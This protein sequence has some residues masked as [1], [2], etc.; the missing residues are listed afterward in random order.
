MK[1]GLDLPASF[2]ERVRLTFEGGETWLAELPAT[3]DF[4]AQQWGLTLHPPYQLSY[5]YAA[6]VTMRGGMPAVLK[7]GVPRPELEREI[8]ALQLYDGWGMCRLLASDVERGAMLLEQLQPGDM[9]TSLQDDDEEIRIAAQTMRNLWRVLPATHPFKPVCRWADGLTRLRQTFDGDVGPFPRHLVE[10]AESMFAELFAAEGDHFLLHG[11]FH[12]FNILRAGDGWKA[13][14]PKGVA[15]EAAYDVGAL[16]HNPRER[17]ADH[18]DLNALMARRVTILAESLPFDPKR[19]AAW[20]TAIAVLSGWWSYEDEG[21]G[22][23]F[24][25]ACAEALLPL[26]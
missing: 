1:I 26:A 14:D 24:A 8:A 20:G 21:A 13:I 12:H 17:L 19:I 5:N 9:L 23:E 15:G 4:F 11:D 10:A 25:F 18:A 2:V 3:L 6:P 22:W 7:I 16:L